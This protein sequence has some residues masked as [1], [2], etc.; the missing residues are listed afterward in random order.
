MKRLLVIWLC[1]L[2]AGPA[3]A[4][5][6]D[7]LPATE[8]EREALAAIERARYVRAR[9]L[10]TDILA[11]D[12][13]SVPAGYAL[14]FALHA[15]EGNIPLALHHLRA[16]RQRAEVVAGMPRTGLTGWHALLLAAEAQALSDLGRYDELLANHRQQR[17]LYADDSEALDVW[18]LMKLGRIEEARAAAARG[19]ASDDPVHQLI[20]L[21]GLCAID[22]YPACME[23]LEHARERDP[24][25][26]LPLRN[27]AVSALEVGRYVEAETLLLESAG[28]TDPNVNPWRDL[29]ALYV[30][31]GR[32]GEAA[33]AARQMIER[34]RNLT[35]R[36]RQYQQAND[37]MTSAQVLLVAGHPE[38]ALAATQRALERPDRS[39]H[40]SGSDLE[41]AAEG[42]LIDRAVRLTLAE[43]AAETAAL[44]PLWRRG[45]DALRAADHRLRAWLS[46]RRLL[47]LLHAGGLRPSAR[48]VDGEGPELSVPDWLLPDVAELFGA[49]ATLALVEELRADPPWDPA[50]LPETVWSPLLRALEVEAHW[51]AG[52]RAACLASGERAL[53]ELP[54]ALVLLRARVAARMADA[55]W[56]R[57]EARAWTLYG[58]VLQ[59][60]PGVLRRLGQ[61][62]PVD[63]A[64]GGSAAAE[65]AAGLALRTPRFVRS[66]GSPF[67]LV[68]RPTSLCLGGPSGSVL[69]CS[70]DAE[71]QAGE[72]AVQMARALL[73]AAFAPRLDLSQQ[74]LTTLD[75]TPVAERG[76]DENVADELLG[77]R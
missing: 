64:T 14:G 34:S 16:A 7:D 68:P 19:R 29:A 77:A 24:A 69:A 59:L 73:A 12:P 15:G 2:G 6:F 8:P 61:P 71:P 63:L 66:A 18:A 52:D 53:E 44:A 45:D 49:G 26:A 55:A 21:N 75:G 3:F 46:G 11:R 33:G 37:L 9:E 72:P 28:R 42:A 47:P 57:G 56:R 39:A 36:L 51:L 30:L 13:A 10:A 50:R 58:T 32:I 5:I 60:D 40:L 70:E 41:L 27:A 54:E 23:L 38:R 20:A 35:P 74:D 48:R 62:L 76:L 31:E 1:L 4:G 43:Q 25:P 22:G 17:T 65:R 67:L